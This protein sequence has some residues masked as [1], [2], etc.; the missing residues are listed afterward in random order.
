MRQE[1]GKRGFTLIEIMI[2]VAIIAILMA[3]MLPNFMRARDT[4][5]KR[6]CLSSLRVIDQSKQQF[7]MEHSKRD[8]DSVGWGDLVPHY[9]R[10]QPACPVGGSYTLGTVGADPTCAIVGHRLH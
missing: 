8:G 7:A 2:V 6:A 4:A 1:L 3:T 5:S 9:M 10:A